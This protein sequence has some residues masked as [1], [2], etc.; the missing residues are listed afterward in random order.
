MCK[1]G[2]K[3][4]L[5]QHL[6]YWIQLL[7]ALS[8]PAIGLTAIIIGVMQWRTAHQRAALDLFDRRWA[9]YE[10]IRS[11]IGE[12][13]REGNVTAQTTLSFAGAINR[14]AFLFGPEVIS[15]LESIRTALSRLYVASRQ[16]QTDQI[17]EGRRVKLADQEA[18]AMIEVSGFL[19]SLGQLV[20]PYMR[21]HQKV[22]FI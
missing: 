22:P 16:L 17:S 15:Q 9:A 12:I 21:M 3:V 18:D 14:A 8:T 2:R 5:E 10:E 19:K 11:V 20:R 7:Q 6:P 4:I 1:A 13:V